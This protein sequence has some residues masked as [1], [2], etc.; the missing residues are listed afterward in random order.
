[1]VAA[2]AGCARAC[3]GL[4]TWPCPSPALPCPSPALFLVDY[5]TKYRESRLALLLLP[6][7]SVLRHRCHACHLRSPCACS[8]L[9]SPSSSPLPSPF[10]TLQGTERACRAVRPPRPAHRTLLPA[11][12]VPPRRPPG[13]SGGRAAAPCAA[14]RLSLFPVH[15]YFFAQHCLYV[16][17]NRVGS[18]LPASILPL[19]PTA[20]PLPC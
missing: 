9:H 12:G 20:P 18:L 5:S 17:Q 11:P 3:G 8:A 16:V 1:M 2:P 13:C 14:R 4:L 10:S 6:A 19:L 15:L 7:L